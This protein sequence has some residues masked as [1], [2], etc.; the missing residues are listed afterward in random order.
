MTGQR[1]YTKAGPVSSALPQRVA[2]NLQSANAIPPAGVRRSESLAVLY[3][4]VTRQMV[5]IE[6]A[7]DTAF[8]ESPDETV[9][10]IFFGF[11]HDRTHDHPGRISSAFLPC[12]AA[13]PRPETRKMKA[14]NQ[15]PTKEAGWIISLGLTYSPRRYSLQPSWR[16]FD[17]ILMSLDQIL[18][19]GFPESI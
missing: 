7:I 6:G 4:L 5:C 8:P 14:R 2:I 17:T 10:I 9:Q 11:I 16:Q 1:C 15:S 18:L 12:P 13:A 19:S 3:P